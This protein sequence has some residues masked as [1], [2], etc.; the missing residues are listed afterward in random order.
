MKRKN[1]TSWHDRLPGLQSLT[2][3]AMLAA[4]TTLTYLGFYTPPVG[5]V[6]RSVLWF[7]SQCLLYAGS[8]FG[9]GA[10]VRGKAAAGPPAPRRTRRSAGSGGTGIKGTATR[11]AAGSHREAEGAL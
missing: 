9:V 10:Y 6:S 2:A 5:E 1:H 8:I 4:G 3:V 7:F 11:K